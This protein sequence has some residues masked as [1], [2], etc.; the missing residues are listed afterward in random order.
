[1]GYTNYF[2]HA[3]SRGTMGFEAYTLANGFQKYFSREDYGPHDFDG[4]WGIFDLPY[5]QYVSNKISDMKEPFVAGI[6][7]LS[8]HQPYR[9]PDE[10]NGKFPKGSLEIHESIG[11]ADFA[12]RKFFETAEKEKW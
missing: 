12:L 4:S 10:F 8:S 2:F 9:I 6:F 5:L 1:A 3:G 7:T 11:Y